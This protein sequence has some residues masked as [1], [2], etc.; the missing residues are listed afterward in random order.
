LIDILRALNFKDDLSPL[1]ASFVKVHLASC[2]SR[3]QIDTRQRLL[4]E[5]EPLVRI[6]SDKDDRQQVTLIRKYHEDA[7][8]A[9]EEDKLLYNQGLL[10]A[11]EPR[12]IDV[13][14]T[15]HRE[16]PPSQT[17]EA[18]SPVPTNAIS[19]DGVARVLDRSKACQCSAMV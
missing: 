18:F 13:N 6:L 16:K 15:V 19:E 4:D 12:R 9:L 10:P 5:E 1:L 14:M 8:K 2:L 7:R 3:S 11:P 17:P